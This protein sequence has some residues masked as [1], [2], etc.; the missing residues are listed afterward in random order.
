MVVQP[1]ARFWTNLSNLC[2]SQDICYVR[3][4]DNNKHDAHILPLTIYGHCG[5]LLNNRVYSHDV[6]AA[7]LVFQNKETAAILVY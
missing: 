2:I 3:M 5:N 1:F 7:I 6:T 4:M